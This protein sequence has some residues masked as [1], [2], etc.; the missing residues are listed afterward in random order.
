MA[1]SQRPYGPS[2]ANVSGQN[3]F[4][5]NV[6]AALKQGV[7]PAVQA[8][9]GTSET[10]LTNPLNPAQ[11]L[12]VPLPGNSGFEQIPFDIYISG[13]VTTL[14]STNVTLKLYSGTSATVGSDVALATSGAVAVNTATAPFF[15]HVH[16]VYDSTSGLF[17]GYYEG[18]FDNTTIARTNI[19][20]QPTGISD[21]NNPAMT[22]LASATS[23]AASA[24]NPT[25]VNTQMFS[26]G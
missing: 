1:Q 20:A 6:Q 22:F 24:S 12:A 14:N 19:T 18:Q 26:A 3:V 11:L 2:P 8:L 10:V 21:A 13:K 23:S 9:A 4:A 5:Q 16:G 25:T 7:L 17:T 15:L